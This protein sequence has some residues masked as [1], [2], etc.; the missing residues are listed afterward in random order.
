ML[1]D[2]PKFLAKVEAVLPVGCVADLLCCARNDQPKMIPDG[3]TESD[4]NGV[5]GNFLCG[6]VE[7]KYF[8]R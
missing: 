8:V 7:G 6:V 2:K 3:E 4:L 5:N 1:D